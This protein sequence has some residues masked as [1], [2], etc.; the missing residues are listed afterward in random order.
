MS[1]HPPD[2]RLQAKLRGMVEAY[3]LKRVSDMLVVGRASLARYLAD[4]Y[5]HAITLRGVE[6][7][8]AKAQFDGVPL[9][10]CPP[11]KLQAKLR[12]IIAADGLKKVSLQLEC[13]CETVA[14]YLA[15]I[16]LHESSFLGIEA[17][18]AATLEPL[19]TRK[20]RAPKGATRPQAARAQP[21]PSGR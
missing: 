6:A 2:R 19:P 20:P 7:S 21:N 11:T 9:D 1:T 14:R 17:L 13:S 12:A 15:N 3:G 4:C 5:V 18:V 10:P 8:I 16:A